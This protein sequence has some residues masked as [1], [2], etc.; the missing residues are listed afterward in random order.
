VIL[1]I[2]GSRDLWVSHDFIRDAIERSPFFP[3]EIVQG[4]ARGVDACALAYATS[5]GILCKE[6]PADWNA[7]GRSAGPIRN[8][9]MAKYG[10]ALIY[11]HRLIGISTGTLNMLN[12]MRSAGKPSF[13]AIVEKPGEMTER[14][15]KHSLAHPCAT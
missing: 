3:T 12:A 8:R 6:F 1:I 2:A 15:W 5:R 9:Q 7:H 11:I 13:G 10:E 4:G 14:S